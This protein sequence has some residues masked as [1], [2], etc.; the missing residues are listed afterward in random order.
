[1]GSRNCVVPKGLDFIRFFE[2]GWQSRRTDSRARTSRRKKH[3]KRAPEGYLCRYSNPLGRPQRTSAWSERRYTVRSV[4]FLD[5][6][7]KPNPFSHESTRSFTQAKGKIGDYLLAWR[8][9]KSFSLGRSVV[10]VGFSALRTPLGA[11]S[12]FSNGITLTLL[13]Q[14]L[15]FHFAQSRAAFGLIY[16]SSIFSRFV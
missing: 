5:C 14:Y 10:T 16:L 11:V 1:M 9:A 2:H 15:I 4:N 7:V 8:G 3:P 6:Q 12:L 13:F